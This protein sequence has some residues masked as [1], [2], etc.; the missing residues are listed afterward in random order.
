MKF[1]YNLLAPGWTGDLLRIFP[2][3]HGVTA[4]MDFNSLCVPEQ[5]QKV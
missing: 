3:T 4:G 5:C 1:N 2:A